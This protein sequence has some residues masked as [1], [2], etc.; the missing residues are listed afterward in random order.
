MAGTLPR[1]TSRMELLPGTLIVIYVI[2]AYGEVEWEVKVNDE[3]C[4]A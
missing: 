4:S 1:T 2:N 3:E